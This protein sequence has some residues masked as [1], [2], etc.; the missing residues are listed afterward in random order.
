MSC[1]VYYDI[2]NNINYSSFYIKGL[3]EVFGRKNVHASS[4]PFSKLHY[5]SETHILAFIVDDR[6][7]VIDFADSNTVFYH[8][9]LEWTDVYGKV[10]YNRTNLPNENQ[11]K[12][13]PCSPN[14]AIP[15]LGNNKF[16]ATFHATINFLKCRNRLDYSFLS[17][18]N[19]YLALSNRQINVEKQT[20]SKNT[21]TFFSRLWSGQEVVNRIRANYIRACKKLD[22]EGL[23]NFIGGLIPDS[24]IIDTTYQDVILNQ[25]IP[26]KLYLEMLNQSRIAF[27]TPAYFNCH[28]WKL[29]EF[30]S[31]GKVILSTPFEN[32]LPTPLIHGQNIFF[33]EDGE[34]DTL[35]LAIRKIVSDRQLQ[36]KLA[37][38]AKKYWLNYG[39]PKAAIL[40]LI[41]H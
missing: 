35:L 14:F 18:L 1:K 25:E 5:G 30:L 34:E 8:S 41:K 3:Q 31:Q 40:Q 16:F 38:G 26:H 12:I 37:L 11:E 20:T 22:N 36:D 19:K 32:E 15:I 2:A 7:Y 33:V 17:F 24:K 27:N 6:R 29:P 21:I 9:F 39:C 10:N 4:V 23:F 13:V 28:G